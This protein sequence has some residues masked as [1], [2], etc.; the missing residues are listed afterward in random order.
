MSR[1]EERRRRTEYMDY[2]PRR[3]GQRRPPS[4]YD[5]YDSLD[6]YERPKK[7]PPTRG[8]RPQNGQR[9]PQGRRPQTRPMPA[10]A[11]KRKKP[12]RST[13]RR[14]LSWTL[15]LL[16]LAGLGTDGA[17]YLKLSGIYKD[18][19]SVITKTPVPEHKIEYICYN[20]RQYY[21]N[22]DIAKFVLLGTDAGVGRE[23]LGARTDVMIVVAIDLKQNK[24][25]GIEI[26][27]DTKAQVDTLDSK[28]RVTSTEMRKINGAFQ[29][30]GRE[31]GY[32]PENTMKAINLLLS[33]DGKYD[34]G[35]QDYAGINMDGLGPLTD[36]VG[37]VTVTLRSDMEGIGRKGETVTLRGEQGNTF[38]RMRKGEGLDG[39]DT[40]RG[41][42]Q[43][44]YI[45]GYM[46][47]VRNLGVSQVP[48]ILSAVS[49][50]TFMNLNTDRVVAYASAVLKVPSSN[51]ELIQ[52]PGTAMEQSPWYYLVDEEELEQLII[53]VF[54]LPKEETSPTA[55]PSN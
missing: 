4:R 35:L 21:E 28:G 8:K 20:G 32:G 42:R 15:T 13:A 33:L 50:Y 55:M 47:K 19:G 11:P 3:S 17:M 26:P 46:A 52:L 9:P 40:E 41:K 14:V 10:A 36:A 31:E 18:P 54:Y 1:K 25:T 45:F 37:G 27:R 43:M 53:D 29:L 24:I 23:E 16:I 30:G 39:S 5:D 38:C 7:Q 34:L 49:K 51:I 48:G 6:Y 22:T 44:D 12:R 2:A